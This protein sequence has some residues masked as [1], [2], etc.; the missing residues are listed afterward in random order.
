MKALLGPVDSVFDPGVLDNLQEPPVGYLG[1]VFDLDPV[2]AELGRDMRFGAHGTIADDLLRYGRQTVFDVFEPRLPHVWPDLTLDGVSCVVVA[3]YLDV[4]EKVRPL[5]EEAVD[6]GSDG[7]V[8]VCRFCLFVVRVQDGAV[9]LCDG[10]SLPPLSVKLG[11]ERRVPIDKGVEAGSKQLVDHK[12]VV[13][14]DEMRT[15]IQGM[16]IGRRRPDRDG[17]ERRRWG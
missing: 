10:L 3:G 6:G 8:K 17:N 15:G 16:R 1:F 5:G 13:D 12:R 4:L 14:K 7:D 11:G 9:R 2:H